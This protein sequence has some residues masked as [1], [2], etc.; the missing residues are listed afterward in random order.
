MSRHARA[1]N[2][3]IERG[4]PVDL[5]VPRYS[6]FIQGVL[7]LCGDNAGVSYCAVQKELGRCDMQT[8][9]DDCRHTCGHCAPFPRFFK[10]ICFVG[11]TQL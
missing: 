7:V 4:R 2:R 3:I 9:I 10:L 5:N 8:V 1:L 6:S 11:G